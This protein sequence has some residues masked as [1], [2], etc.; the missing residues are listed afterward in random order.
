MMNALLRHF[1]LRVCV[2]CLTV[3]GICL[4]VVSCAP[5]LP[6]PATLMPSP[7]PTTIPTVT[8]I[9]SPTPTPTPI[10][11]HVVNLRWPQQVSAL[12]PV[13]I[14]VD[15]QSP[16]GVDEQPRVRARLFDPGYRVAWS[17]DLLKGDGTLYYGEDP[18]E[19]ALFPI[20]GEWRLQVYVRSSLQVVG[21]LSHTFQPSPIAFRELSY[22]LPSA[23]TMSIPAVFDEELA[24]GDHVSGARVWRYSDGEVSLWW[25]PGSAETLL[26]NTAV[27]MLEATFVSEM[28]PDV[29]DV[30]EGEWKGQPAFRFV[31]NWPGPG[32]G[33]SEAWVIQGPEYW[34]YVLRLRS[35]GPQ[36]VSPL[37]HEVRDSFAF[38][39][40]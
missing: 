4:L 20:E 37:L 7:A 16:R 14:K 3:S 5:A 26:L 24:L 33:T 19:F 31:E 27:V 34:L 40:D 9:P 2:L 17:G 8:P 36:G 18:V 11:P 10:P 13:T 25:A 29:L 30:E 38:R 22:T 28:S 6:E 39:S 12:D 15:V 23:A 35:V 21:E 32:D 1:R